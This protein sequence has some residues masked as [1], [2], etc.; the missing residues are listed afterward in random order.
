MLYQRNRSRRLLDSANVLAQL[1]DQLKNQQQ[2][3]P[4]S[5]SPSQ[6]QPS[7][8]LQRDDKQWDIMEVMH[9]NDR[10]P[11]ELAHILHDA[12]VVITPHGFQA[13]L[14]R[15]SYHSL[16][17]SAELTVCRFIVADVVYATTSALLRDISR[18]LLQARL[19][20][21]VNRSG[22]VIRFVV[23]GTY[24]SADTLGAKLRS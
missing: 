7:L 13:M 21:T 3:M 5:S 18:S 1:R 14:V 16:P 12:D 22:L 9:D 4:D 17:C 11:C 6:Q 10:S 20:D 15:A 8:T 19:S 23:L 24:G 2:S